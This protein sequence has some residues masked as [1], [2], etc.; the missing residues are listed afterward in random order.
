MPT[1]EGGIDGDGLAAGSDGLAHTSQTN[2]GQA[3]VGMGM[4]HLRLEA[5]RGFAGSERLGVLLLCQQGDSEGIVGNGVVGCEP[6]SSLQD[7]CCL[8]RLVALQEQLA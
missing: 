4:G 1:S 7:C 5:N 2:Q 8:L 3:A 6:D